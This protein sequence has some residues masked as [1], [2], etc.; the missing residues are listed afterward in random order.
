VIDIDSLKLWEGQFP[1]TRF[2]L[3]RESAKLLGEEAVVDWRLGWQK[4]AP[5]ASTASREPR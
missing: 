1:F 4:A 3:F 2:Q 5:P